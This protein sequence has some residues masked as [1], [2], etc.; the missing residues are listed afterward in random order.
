[1]NLGHELYSTSG[2]R[3]QPSWVDLPQEMSK[4]AGTM[5]TD[6]SELH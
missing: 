4:E 5:G 3:S 6:G 1:M 2:I